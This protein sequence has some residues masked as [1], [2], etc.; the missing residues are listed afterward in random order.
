MDTIGAGIVDQTDRGPQGVSGWLLVF[1]VYAALAA[2]L[3]IILGIVF[4]MGQVPELDSLS[5]GMSLLVGLIFLVSA[6]LIVLRKKLARI[7]SLVA[8]GILVAIG[9]LTVGM[10]IAG[11]EK[12]TLAEAGQAARDLVLSALWFLYI[13]RSRRVANTLVN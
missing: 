3:N 5:A 8:C 9:F 6:I 11:F 1:V 13:L 4:F 2:L 7:L 10:M 12:V